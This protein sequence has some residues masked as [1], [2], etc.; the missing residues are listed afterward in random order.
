MLF[1]TYSAIWNLNTFCKKKNAFIVHFQ[2]IASSHFT[3]EA[4]KHP[5][6]LWIEADKSIL[7]NQHAVFRSDEKAACHFASKTGWK[8]SRM[9][10]FDKLDK[11]VISSSGCKIKIKA[12][13]FNIFFTEPAHYSGE[14]KF[15]EL[16]AITTIQSMITTMFVMHLHC[17]LRRLQG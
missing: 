15:P 8:W 5:C 9:D 13:F 10:N 12:A 1:S 6:C 4:D 3:A 16:C 7:A 14:E 17:Q 2:G 11:P